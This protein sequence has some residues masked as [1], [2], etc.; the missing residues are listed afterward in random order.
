MISSHRIIN[1]TTKAV[2]EQIFHTKSDRGSNK[3][4]KNT[5][6]TRPTPLWRRNDV[7][8]ISMANVKGEKSF[9]ESQASVKN[10]R[11]H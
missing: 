5:G 3:T 4:E 1:G 9:D 11:I 2:D 6:K 10:S 7:P 8:E